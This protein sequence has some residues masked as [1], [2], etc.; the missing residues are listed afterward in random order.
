MKS[1]LPTCFL[2]LL[3]IVGCGK[4]E[5]AQVETKVN[6]HPTL[7]QAAETIFRLDEDIDHACFRSDGN[8]WLLHF[9]SSD[10]WFAATIKLFHIAENNSW[11]AKA[12]DP[13]SLL[14]I[15][16]N[17]EGMKSCVKANR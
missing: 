5:T 15:Y 7:E 11:F 2:I 8:E 10:K 14:Q 17:I 16:P 9:K 1:Y 12:L 3:L 4:K 6:I 13:A